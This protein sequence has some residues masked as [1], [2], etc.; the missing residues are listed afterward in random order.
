ML[1]RCCCLLLVSPTYLL[2]VLLSSEPQGSSSETLSSHFPQSVTSSFSPSLQTS[3]SPQD[4]MPYPQG[5]L[6]GGLVPHL[7]LH[8]QQPHPSP[9]LLSSAGGW[10]SVPGGQGAPRLREGAAMGECG[11][12][13]GEKE[14]GTGIRNGE[15]GIDGRL[16]LAVSLECPAELLATKNRGCARC[17]T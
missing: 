2:S 8:P 12:S 10:G 9:L 5:L 6:P 13:C 3:L 11:L 4:H 1:R 14:G 17:G 16:S 7:P 15:G